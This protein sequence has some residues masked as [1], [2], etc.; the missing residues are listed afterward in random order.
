MSENRITIEL[1]KAQIDRVIREATEDDGLLGLLGLL[2]GRRELDAQSSPEQLDDQRLSRSLL[3]G[4]MILTSFRTNE[5]DRSVTD[6]ARQLD[7]S[8]ST[9]HRYISTLVHVGLLARDPRS[10]RYRLARRG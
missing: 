8:V 3:L 4:L 9:A 2:G 7:L 6:V 5:V 1:S 10:R